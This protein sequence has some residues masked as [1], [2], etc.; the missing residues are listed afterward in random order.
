MQ[1]EDSQSGVALIAVL[2]ALAVF[3]LMALGFFFLVTGDQAVTGAERDNTVAF[4]GAEGALENMSSQL[5]ALFSSTSSPTPAQINALD[6]QPPSIPDVTFPSQSSEFPNGGYYIGYQTNGSGGLVSTAETIGG[7]SALAGLTGVIT[8]FT[9]T[10]IAQGP[11]NTEVKLVRQVQEVAVPIFEFGIFSNND[12]AFF[13]GPNFDFG[14]RVGTN[15]NLYLTEGPGTT[16]TLPDKVT[17]YE[18]VITTQLE[19][20]WTTTNNYDGT[21]QIVTTPGNYGDLLPNMGSLTGGPGSSPDPN[22]K[23]IS[24]TT[25]DGNILTELTGAKELNMSFAMPGSGNSPIQII[26]RDQPS[27]SSNSQLAQ[28]RLENQ[29]SLR[30]L[31]SDS[32]STTDLPDGTNAVSLNQPLGAWYPSDSCHAP[33]ALSPGPAQDADFATP[34]NTPLIGG[35]IEIDIQTS[36][37]AWVNVTQDVLSQ[38]ITNDTLPLGLPCIA[39]L[40]DYYPILHLEQVN[41]YAC[42]SGACKSE[43]ATSGY[44]YIPVNMYDTREGDLRDVNSGLIS[45]NGVM[46][47]IELDVHNLQWWFANDTYGKQ[48]LE[49]SGY[50]VYF[51]DR[52][53]N[54]NGSGET[55]AY[56]NEDIVNP[57]SS[58]G[59]PDGVMEAPEDVDGPNANTSNWSED[60]FDTYGAKPSCAYSSSPDYPCPGSAPLNSTATPETSVSAGVAA[61]NAVIFFRHALRLVDG[62][63]GSLPPLA[64]ANCSVAPGGNG[65]GGFTVAAENAVYVEGNYNASNP[66]FSDVLGACHVPAAVMADAVTLISNSWSDVNSFSS[67]TNPGGR[68]AAVTYYRTAVMGGTNIPFSSYQSGTTSPTFG[69]SYP[70]DFGTDGGVHNFLRLL[71]NWNNVNLYYEG[72]LADFYYSRQ[73]TGVY[74]CC[75][76][77]YNP[78]NRDYSFDTEFENINTIPP[79]TPHFTDVNALGFQQDLLP[80]Q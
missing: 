33:L 74:K 2:L 54:Y 53:G 8:P 46:N 5:A 69:Y 29:A 9:L 57:A 37:G 15:G 58:S 51:S 31:L 26:E 7:T 17:A 21:V 72:S 60:Q 39:S 16:L 68:N 80:S 10:V 62:S 78:P 65:Y 67:P 42:T 25:F 32:N 66:S 1:R 4:Y 45:L 23:T 43:P 13:A 18:N 64:A 76:T 59:T 71:E 48:A 56:G 79:G 34:L 44:D 50:I 49:N 63:L 77:V 14:G 27:D 22:W 75:T 55:G 20:G 3:S 28:A 36:S 12:L 73:A 35:Y 70:E 19:N 38:G 61:K 24:L 47:V 41:T 52:R 40:H 11:N 6:S 30:I